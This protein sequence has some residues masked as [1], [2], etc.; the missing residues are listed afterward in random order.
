[1]LIN[2]YLV[3]LSKIFVPLWVY[4][5]ILGSIELFLKSI[6]IKQYI[7][8]APSSI[9]IEIVKSF[10]ILIYNVAVSFSIAIASFAL[11]IVIAFVSAVLLAR[12]PILRRV[13]LPGLI[14]M[15]AIPLVALAPY[16]LIWFGPGPFSRVLLSTL[17]VFFPA[18][19]IMFNGL[20]A[21]NKDTELL[22]KSI[23][24]SEGRMFRHVTIPSAV[25]AL[26]SAMEVTAALSVIGAVVAELAGQPNGIGFVIMQATYV[27]D[28]P[29][30]FAVLT[31]GAVASLA[32]YYVVGMAGQRLRQKV[33]FHYGTN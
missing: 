19:L 28:T 5:L 32:L 33:A 1:M 25:P 29:R 13:A 27:Y 22:F 23:R 20:R 6:N 8:P 2:K 15:Q 21:R 4:V 9:F 26:A 16:F 24:I 7:F 30:V 10:P 11:G 14:A 12:L 3:P 31:L 17:L 18:L